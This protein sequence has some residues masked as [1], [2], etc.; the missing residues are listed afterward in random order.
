MAEEPATMR[1]GSGSVRGS[2]YVFHSG[3]RL[4]NVA[5]LPD[6]VSAPVL[7]FTN[8]QQ[9]A[10]P[11]RRIPNQCQ[12]CHVGGLLLCVCHGPTCLPDVLCRSGEAMEEGWRG[13]W[14]KLFARGHG[15][16]GDGSGG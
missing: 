9:L 12:S 5:L 1:S 15:W 2:Q 4:T 10:S 3:C 13:A 8:N 7:S 16:I 6:R 14:G 11:D